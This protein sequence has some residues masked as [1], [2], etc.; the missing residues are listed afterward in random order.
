MA[1][2]P[3]VYFTKTVQDKLQEDWVTYNLI[4]FVKNKL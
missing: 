3:L 1:S 4:E 2:I